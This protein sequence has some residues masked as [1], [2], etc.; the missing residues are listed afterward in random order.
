MAALAAVVMLAVL[1]VTLSGVLTHEQVVAE[2]AMAVLAAAE[3]QLIQ[4][5][6]EQELQ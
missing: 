2:A 5:L 3:K 4:V 1:A 6:V